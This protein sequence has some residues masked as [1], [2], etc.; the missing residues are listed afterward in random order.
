MP[1]QVSFP[2][3]GPVR[4]TG[5]PATTYLDAISMEAKTDFT[6]LYACVLEAR[7]NEDRM[8]VIRALSRVLDKTKNTNTPGIQLA[9]L[10]RLVMDD[11]NKFSV[12]SDTRSTT[13]RL[14]IEELD[15]QQTEEVDCIDELCKIFE[16][17]QSNLGKNERSLHD[18]RLQLQ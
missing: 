2:P 4:L 14:L 7:K 9:T 18:V 1:F 10:L 13:A 11:I 6:L 15:D 16:A 5:S 8:T 12:F 17:G 3:L